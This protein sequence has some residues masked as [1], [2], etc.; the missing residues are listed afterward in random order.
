MKYILTGVE[1]LAALAALALVCAIAHMQLLDALWIPLAMAVFLILFPV[2]AVTQGAM[3]LKGLFDLGLS[4]RLKLPVRL[5]TATLTAFCVAGSA[6]SNARLMLRNAPTRFGVP[7]PVLWPWVTAWLNADSHHPAAALGLVAVLAALA[8]WVAAFAICVSWQQ[9][10]SRSLWRMIAGALA[11][12]AVGSAFAWWAVRMSGGLAGWLAN[13]T[14]NSWFV[15]CFLGRG[16]TGVA[17][18]AHAGAFL[19]FLL[20]LALYA[21]LGIYGWKAL[22]KRPTVPAL[23]APLM[24]VMVLGWTGSGAEFYLGRWHFPLLLAVAVWGLLN[25]YIPWADHVYEMIDREQPAA[26]P[27]FQVLKAHGKNCAIVVAT[28]GGGIQAAAWT[29]QVLEGLHNLYGEDFDKALCLIS[30]ISGGSLGNAC[31]VN[32]LDKAADPG[33]PRPSLA[34]AASSLD[35]VAWGLAWP[36]LLRLFFPWPFGLAIDRAGAMEKAWTGNASGLDVKFEGQLE[37]AVSRWNAK[38]GAGDLPAVVMNSTMVEVGGPLLLGTTDVNGDTHRKSDCWMDGDNLHVQCNKP[39]DI[40]AVRAARLSATFPF[41]TP[42]ARPKYANCQPH[43]MDGGFYDNY[44]MAT[45]TE[46]LDQAL[47]KQAS[48]PGEPQVKR[49][50]VIQINGFPPAGFSVPPPPKT[51]GGW[52]LQFIAPIKILVNVRTAGQVSHRDI[53]LYL[54]VEKWRCRGIEIERAKFELNEANA[55][56]SWH[57]MPRQ[58]QAIVTGWDS[59]EKVQAAKKKVGD[60]LRGCHPAEGPGEAVRPEDG[61]GAA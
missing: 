47:E 16:Y 14:A 17:W 43:M 19:T 33:L 28:A 55:P 39:M 13:K 20:V 6:S 44:G 49:V 3:L 54:T 4:P 50:L 52:L 30:S 22:G 34:A 9:D 12:I 36:D 59:D 41:V 24:V 1:V 5:F 2:Y 60:F 10:H 46:W 18:A 25:D 57:L 32:W 31:Y 45:L 15:R 23:I 29:A 53:E 40:P 42:A 51:H 26:P 27:P 8:A 11:A 61:A 58:K 7:S 38:T 21:G 48:R 56:L 37:N 35:E